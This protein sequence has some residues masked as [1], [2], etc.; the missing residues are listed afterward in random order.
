MTQLRDLLWVRDF[1]IEI[2]TASDYDSYPEGDNK[3]DDIDWNKF[4]YYE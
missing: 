4:D 1:N 2:T 3:Y